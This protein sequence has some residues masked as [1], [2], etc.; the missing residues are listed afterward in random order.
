MGHVAL[1]VHLGL[2]ALGGGRQR[3]DAKHAR[4]HPLG[5]GLDRAALACRVTALEDHHDAQASVLR[6][7]LQLDELDVQRLELALEVLATHRFGAGAGSGGARLSFGAEPPASS[8]AVAGASLGSL[9]F[10]LSFFDIV[11]AS[12][13]LW[14]NRCTTPMG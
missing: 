8:V 12:L 10:L 4:T 9:S 11:S 6:P 14:P 2:F 1:D 7:E 3:H 13:A 5:N